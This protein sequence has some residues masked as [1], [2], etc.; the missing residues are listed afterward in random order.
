MTDIKK[1]TE[2]V[3][4]KGFTM[5]WEHHGNRGFHKSFDD[6]KY[7]YLNDDKR[8]LINC[9][10]KS[11]NGFKMKRG[12]GAALI[13]NNELR[14]VSLLEKTPIIKSPYNSYI[15]KD[16]FDEINRRRAHDNQIVPIETIPRFEINE[17]NTKL[18]TQRANDVEQRANDAEQ[19]ANDAEQMVNELKLMLDSHENKSIFN[20][21]GL[22]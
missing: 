10:Q 5:G 9:I 19:R 7:S 1:L 15:P 14:D 21:Y 16:L 13:I 18:L 2:W 8:Y 3:Y 11:P 6:A 4:V 22:L 12:P 17:H 20:L